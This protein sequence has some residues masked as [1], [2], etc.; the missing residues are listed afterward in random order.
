MQAGCCCPLAPAMVVRSATIA[1]LVQSFQFD[2]MKFPLR[3]A[4]QWSP[5]GVMA[6]LLI[7]TFATS[8]CRSEMFMNCWLP[9]SGMQ[10][11]LANRSFRPLF[12]GLERTLLGVA[13]VE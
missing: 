11:P 8:E 3:A 10:S 5:S 13:R 9:R 7:L 2:V 4:I 12:P 1:A 6:L